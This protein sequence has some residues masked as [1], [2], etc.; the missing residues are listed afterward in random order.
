M[1]TLTQEALWKAGE[2]A[3]QAREWHAVLKYMI[4]IKENEEQYAKAWYLQ[5]LA[6]EALGQWEAARCAITTCLH[7]HPK[8]ISQVL[9]V[10]R[11]IVNNTK[12]DAE[13]AAK[14]PLAKGALVHS[15]Q[16][17]RLHFR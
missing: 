11:R 8:N 12:R 3:W 4:Q 2:E 6:H 16:R 10:K 1:S 17:L 14:Q 7:A 15:Q 9:T 13:Q 5:A